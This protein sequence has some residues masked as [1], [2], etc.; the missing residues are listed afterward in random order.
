ML[1][2]VRGCVDIQTQ[3]PSRHTI[4]RV[5]T[6]VYYIL[7]L[8]LVIIVYIAYIHTHTRAQVCVYNMAMPIK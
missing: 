1:F 7:Q 3:G 8:A 2:D 6:M 4:G 5:V